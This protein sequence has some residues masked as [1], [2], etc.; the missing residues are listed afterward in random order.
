MTF[1]LNVL[2]W[3]LRHPFL[4]LTILTVAAVVGYWYLQGLSGVAM[5]TSFH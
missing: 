1:V 4:S 5:A 3:L 2:S